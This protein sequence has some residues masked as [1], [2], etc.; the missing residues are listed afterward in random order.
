M[1]ILTIAALS[2]PLLL[3]A[4]PEGTNSPSRLPKSRSSLP[5]PAVSYTFEQGK[6]QDDKGL[7]AGSLEN[8][9]SIINICDNHVLYT[10][11]NNGYMDL[12]KETGKSVFADI[13]DF[14]ISIDVFSEPDNNLNNLGNFI[15]CFSSLY[16]VIYGT[17]QDD[18]QYIFI[19][20]KG[21]SY[22]INDRLYSSQQA[23]G[24]GEN[25]ESGKWQNITYVQ[26]GETGT[27][28]LNGQVI[29]ER[30][31]M[32]IK[33]A[34]M[35]GNFI[36]NWLGRSC[37]GND[38]YLKN[39]FIDN[40]MIFRS[41]LTATQ[42]QTICQSLEERN[43]EMTLYKIVQQIDLGQLDRIKNDLNLPTE[44]DGH[45]IEWSSSAP[46]I[47]DENGKVHRPGVDA[48]DME[49]TLTASVSES[50]KTAHKTF[51]GTVIHQYTDKASADL[52]TE[53]LNIPQ[54]Y[55]D[56]ARWY[57]PLD[58]VGEY[59]SQISWTSSAPD[60]I[61]PTGK[62]L[63]FS[64]PG[65]DKTQVTLT[66]TLTKGKEKRQKQFE[67]TV[68]YPE[69]QYDGYLFAYFEGSGDGALQ[70]HLRFGV[71]KDAV[72]WH[73]LNENQPV[74]N[75]DTISITGG[76]RD[77]HILRG[78]DGKTFFIVATDMYVH[79]NGWGSNPGIVLMK[80]DNLINWS[81]A[82][83]NLSET[84]PEHFKDAYW[85]WA[86]QTIYDPSA[87]KYMIYFTLKR[88]TS[89]DLVTYYAYANDDFTAFE[90]E[91]KILFSAK[92]GS[93]DND[94]IYKDG[95][96]HLFYKGNTKNESGQEIKNGIQ[97]ATCST[98]HGDWK[99]DFKYL[100]VYAG[101]T[102]V[103]GSGVFK[104]NEKGY[105]LMYDLYTSLRYEYQ[106]SDDLFDFGNQAY[107]FTKDFNPR[108]GTVTGITKAE[109]R[110]LDAK[111]GGVPGD[112][113]DV[114]TMAPTIG[115]EITQNG[116]N[117]IIRTQQ[118]MTVN[119]YSLNGQRV[120]YKQMAAKEEAQITLT[121]GV[122]IINNSKYLVIE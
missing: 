56:N 65:E 90:E 95:I 61:D 72:N 84:Y 114:K 111:W 17:N 119:I 54:G 24:Y 34:D 105:V 101:K 29:Q 68:A 35:A 30:T 33:P 55:L 3:Q 109:A 13:K 15:C 57:I 73:A 75:S 53:A 78:E 85:V 6:P 32:T 18:V 28:Y 40:F 22:T 10:G 94:I 107:S 103:E 100:D 43:T 1:R 45:H 122:Y 26:K 25:L 98:L 86:P 83:I 79:R 113:T 74:I 63:K 37:W 62:L 117:I 88:S 66:A 96:W 77:P 69:P 87:G 97:Q 47:I 42:V 121:S 58:T 60:V 102:P 91:P 50:G 36:Y 12:G 80:S 4:S 11:A 104:H 118:S 112:L 82:S 38:S 5:T 48:T 108:H 93:I 89:A 31:D 59:E 14:T 51:S 99:E 64:T 71:S 7:Y 2:I 110:R 27:F 21:L 9:A 16:P 67:A 81:H 19:G 41:P 120:F 70:E 52:D 92:Y 39:A 23:V 46:E 106:L 115:L 44:I 49:V 76:I 8:N 20:A 116:S